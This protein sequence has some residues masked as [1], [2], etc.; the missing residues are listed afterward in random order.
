LVEVQASA[1]G[2]AFSRAQFDE[3]YALAEKGISELVAAQ[4]AAVA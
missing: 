2:S 3:L 4:N 1:E